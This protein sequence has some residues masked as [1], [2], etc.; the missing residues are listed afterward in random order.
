[1]SPPEARVPRAARRTAAVLSQV[2]NQ[3]MALELPCPQCG[4][5]MY[6]EQA[7]NRCPVC[8]YIEPCCDGAPQL[9][10]V[11]AAAEVEQAS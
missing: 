2:R 8:L 7:H 1:M 9:C 10:R 4:E 5:Q 6:P 3:Y 11:D